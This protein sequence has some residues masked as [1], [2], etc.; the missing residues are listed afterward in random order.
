MLPDAGV[1]VRKSVMPTYSVHS[2]DN[3][4]EPTPIAA[5]AIRFPKTCRAKRRQHRIAE[6]RETG[7]SNREGSSAH[8]TCRINIQRVEAT[9]QLQHDRQADAGFGGR[10]AQNQ[11]EH[12]LAVGLPPAAAGHHECQ[13]GGIHHDFQAHQHEQHVASHQ[14]ADQAEREQDRRPARG[15]VPAGIPSC[16]PKKQSMNPFRGQCHRRI[17][18]F[19]SWLA[20]VP[21][22]DQRCKQ[23]QRG[24]L[25]HQQVRAVKRDAD[26]LWHPM[27]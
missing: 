9:I 18:S 13:C 27:V 3:P 4:M 14:Q 17:Y 1:L 22:R 5:A 8:L 24:Q 21:S 16:S 23:Q 7:R 20:R 12:D 11:N 10:Q 26:L 6:Q 15:R 19:S 2:A 25:N